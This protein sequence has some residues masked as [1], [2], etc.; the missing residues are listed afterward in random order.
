MSNK[1][2]WN[3]FQFPMF[4]TDWDLNSYRNQWNEFKSS[5]DKAWDQFQE[6]QQKAQESWKEQWDTFF[7]QCIEMQKVFAE[8]LPDEKIA[9]P[10]MPVPPLSPKEAVEK[11][12]EFQKA[13]N[14]QAVKQ[15]DSLFDFHMKG[16]Q[17]VKEMVT[18][19][20]KNVE[21]TLDAKKTDE[22]KAEKEAK[23]TVTAAAK[24]ADVKPRAKKASKP[25]AQK[26]KRTAKPAAAKAA[27]AKPAAEKASKPAEEQK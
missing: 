24:K 7:G 12:V 15:N 9:A 5:I 4:D 1:K 16:Q 22:P 23:E 20:V 10:G 13:A 27:A 21:E 11:A 17:Q 26:T 14:E 25:A 8:S 6:M 19:A 2:T 3:P 18:G